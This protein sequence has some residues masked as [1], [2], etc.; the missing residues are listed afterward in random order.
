MT[1]VATTDIKQN[2]STS[3]IGGS[4]GR[5]HHLAQIVSFRLANEEYGLDIMGVQEIIL[6]G[7]ITGIPEV[8][9]YIRGLINLRGKVIPIVDLRKRFA[10][11][12]GEPTE[13]TRIVVVN[14]AACTFGIIVDAVNEV[15]RIDTEQIEPPPTGLLGR[16]QA[17]IKGLVKMKDKIMILLSTEKMLSQ[18]E[19]VTL[20]E[21]GGQS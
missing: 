2:Q 11:Q 14:T 13:Q 8:P 15:L 12:A 17:Y 4:A 1:A 18:E 16:E 7:E 20:T 19:Q 5:S 10:L 6:M 9:P 21:A 3:R